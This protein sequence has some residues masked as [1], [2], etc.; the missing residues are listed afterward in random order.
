MADA[1]KAAEAR[2]ASARHEALAPSAPARDGRARR[3][4]S[5]SP[6]DGARTS[7]PSST[8][9][10]ATGFVAALAAAP[11]P[12]AVAEAL[13][14]PG[15]HL[16]AEV[17]RRSPSAGRHR[18]RRTTPSPAPGAY[19]AG[20]ASVI[21]VLCEP[22]W[23]GGSV[24]D[25]R[26]VRAAGRRPRARQGLRRR[27]PAARPPPGCRGRPRP[28]AGGAPPAGAA[29]PARR[30]RPATSAWSRWSR[31]TTRARSRPRS[32]PARGS[33]G[34]TTAT[35]GRST[36]TRS[37]PCA[38]RELIPG[39]R[40]A[41]AESGVRDA[42]TV[43]RWRATGFDAAL[44]GEALMR[45]RR[46]GRRRRARSSPPAAI[47]A[48][49]DRRRP[50]AVRQDLR[51]HRRGRDPRR[52]P[53]GRRRHRAQL[54]ARDAAR[55][56]D[57]GGRRARPARPGR[58]R[59][60]AA[61]AAD[62]RSSRRTSRPDAPA[63]RSCD[64]VD[65]DAIQLSGD[66]PP[67]ALA[68]AGR[69]AWKALRVAAGRRP[70]RGRRPRP[71]LPRRPAPTRIL[72]DTAGGPHPGGTGVRVDAA[73][74]AA[75]AREVPVTLAG[76]LHAGNVADALLAI[77]AVGVD[78]ASGT[79][80]PR[81]STGRAPAQGPAARRRCSPSARATPAGIDPTSPSARRPST[82]A[83]SRPTARAGGARSATSAGGTCPRRWSRRSSSSRPPTTRS[84][85]IRGSG[86]SSTTCSATSSAA[87]PRCT[88][89][90]ASP[91]TRGS[92]RR[93]PGGRPGAGSVAHDPGDPA[94]PQA[95]GPRP[96][97]C[98]QDQ[99]RARPGPADPAAGQD[100]GDRRDR[101]RPARR[102]DG[103]RVRAA[104]PAVRRVHGRGGHPAP[105]AER[106]P[107]ARP[108]RRGPLGHLRHGHA[109]GR[110]QRGDAR[111][112]DQRRVDALRPR[113][114]DG[115]APVSH[116]RP[117]PPAADRRRGGGAAVRGR[118]AAARTSPSPAS[119][120][121]RTPSGCCRGSS[122][123]RRSGSRWR[124]RPAMAWRPGATRRRSRAARRGS[125]TGRGR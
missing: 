88:A 19:A 70:G 11:G 22:H 34:S 69:P 108:R 26:A 15:L 39:D 48:D 94:V 42:A 1:A 53:R 113:V 118:G 72:L 52:R 74:A 36:W 107:D 85:T 79:D 60:R 54:R 49:L 111:L 5:R 106:A 32:P 46:P 101:R 14:A 104:R 87:R 47:R 123:S 57:R 93:L 56:V 38:L 65:P 23:F 25:L 92:R 98:P 55:A 86:P 18:R 76:G 77:P 83:C 20:G 35:S 4:R 9:R 12:R 2:Q 28:A 62:R 16:I 71:D 96:H 67:S 17:K 90:I 7:R 51:R 81:E 121:A 91:P 43:A 45:A 114:G 21:S 82:P 68:A 105:G 37:R 29:R 109:Q 33:S 73:L 59:P 41:I 125:C 3:R 122:A 50:R 24:D 58:R 124:R 13:A 117:R 61:R 30:R 80:A 112:G 97:R 100:P 63:A 10:A 99:Q 31:P 89:P 27:S 44:V 115:P 119:A 110:G 102:R 103:D 95:R 120:A 8:A 66:E 40:L 78:V 6:R 75:V 116:D 64:A 84:A